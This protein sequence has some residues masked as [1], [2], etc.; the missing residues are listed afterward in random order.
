M[1]T[2]HNIRAIFSQLDD[3]DSILSDSVFLHSLLHSRMH[4]LD[5]NRK[6]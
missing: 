6:L 4:Y 1:E 2:T 5:S 3:S